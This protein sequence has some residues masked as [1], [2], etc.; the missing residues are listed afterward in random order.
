MRETEEMIHIK[1]M[2][3]ERSYV[4]ILTQAV[5]GWSIVDD[6]I[7]FLFFSTL[8]MGKKRKKVFR[9]EKIRRKYLKI[10]SGKLEF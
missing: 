7:C 1:T 10:F 2:L 5:P 4:N 6:V 3:I 9:R 8:Q